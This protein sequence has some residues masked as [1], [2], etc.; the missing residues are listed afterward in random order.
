[1]ALHESQ[2]RINSENHA[3]HRRTAT[4]G[5]QAVSCPVRRPQQPFCT[6]GRR[7]VS[8]FV[9]FW[10]AQVAARRSIPRNAASLD[11]AGPTMPAIQG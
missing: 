10:C 6:N 11:A 1:M 9:R 8:L 7:F 2:R 4:C 3:I 5:F